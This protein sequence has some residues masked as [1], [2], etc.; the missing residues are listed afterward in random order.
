MLTFDTDILRKKLQL[1]TYSQNVLLRTQAGTATLLAA[2]ERVA[3]S[4]PLGTCEATDMELCCRTQALYEAVRRFPKGK[5][6]IQPAGTAAVEIDGGGMRRRIDAGELDFP[7]WNGGKP[8]AVAELPAAD[9]SAMVDTVLPSASKDAT[10]PSLN[11]ILLCRE[12][13]GM[14]RM[15]ATD[16]HRLAICDRPA[17]GERLHITIPQYAAS[18]LRDMSGNGS[19]TVKLLFDGIALHAE[20]DG[21]RLSVRPG[22]SRLFPDY[23]AIIPEHRN[24][25]FVVGVD[26]M[27]KALERALPATDRRVRG[28]TIRVGRDS[29]TVAAPNFETEVAQRGNAEG[30]KFAISARYLLNAI[31]TMR[32]TSEVEFSIIDA[33]SAVTLRESGNDRSLFVIMPLRL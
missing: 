9:L 29:L 5:I 28:V 25:A 3:L 2:D 27:K 18:V 22:E 26:A 8:C 33:A 16:S 7:E 11:C 31:E 24:A 12:E 17:P 20:C 10:R 19:D 14:L 32:K 4:A 13:D 23:R 21:A 15:A 30:A 6:R 1:A